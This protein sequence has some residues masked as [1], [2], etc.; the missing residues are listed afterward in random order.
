[1]RCGGHVFAGL[2]RKLLLALLQERCAE[3]GVVLQF[4]TEV[5]SLAD[6]GDADLLIAA[7][8]VNS[9]ARRTYQ[10]VFQP[11]LVLGR[12]RY[13]WFGTDRV[14]DAFT[15]IFRENE[16]GL[17]QVHAYPFSGATSTFIVECAEDVW[18]PA[19]L[20]QAN[21]AESIAYCERLFA[22]ELRGC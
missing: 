15:F 18:Q 11:S 5:A 7:D 10:S 20:G 22:P 17:F 8:G 1:V 12:A 16:H 19:G 3:L 4:H 6:L 2:S 21:E 9:L 14:L 13:I